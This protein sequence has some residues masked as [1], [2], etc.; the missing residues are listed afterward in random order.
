MPRS[1]N[2]ASRNTWWA[3]ANS[4]KR[5]GSEQQLR[6]NGVEAAAN[7]C[8]NGSR[9]DEAACCELG[10]GKES[11]RTKTIPTARSEKAVVCNRR[12]RKRRKCSQSKDARAYCAGKGKEMGQEGC[13]LNYYYNMSLFAACCIAQT[14]T[15]FW[16]PLG[17][18]ADGTVVSFLDTYTNGGRHLE[19]G[20][21]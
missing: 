2:S 17:F 11:S 8:S 18:F 21:T 5:S 3:A 20:K 10:W 7:N 12:R 19:A 6:S 16:D 9:N 15:N 14:N 4:D 13:R 1:P